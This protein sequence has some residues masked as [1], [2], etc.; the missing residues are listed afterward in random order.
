MNAQTRALLIAVFYVAAVFLSVAIFQEIFWGGASALLE[1]KIL[2]LIVGHAVVAILPCAA[3]DFVTRKRNASVVIGSFAFSIIFQFIY[4]TLILYARRRDI[5][6]DLVGVDY[7]TQ[8]FQ[9]DPFALYII[10]AFI[11]CYFYFF[12]LSPAFRG[13]R[14]IG[15][16]KRSPS[17][18]LDVKFS[19]ILNKIP[20]NR[21]VQIVDL[22]NRAST[23]FNVSNIILLGIVILLVLSAIFIIFAGEIT[24]LGADIRDPLS[25]AESAYRDTERKL[26]VAR[27]R[28]IKVEGDKSKGSVSDR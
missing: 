2:P 24:R 4:S 9:L 5:E 22:R 23:L 16:D 27:E 1:P 18:I 11:A 25:M 21:A 13:T 7:E 12:W 8:I 19:Q 3:L 20:K 15:T 28:K 14:A 17:A 26:D 6:G 10:L